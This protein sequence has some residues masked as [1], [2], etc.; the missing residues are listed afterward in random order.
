VMGGGVLG[1][2]GGRW[3][4]WGGAGWP[5]RQV[6]EGGG[7]LGG[8]GVRWVRKGGGGALVVQQGTL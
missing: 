4:Q 3:V 5:G 2:L 8:L 1:G 6:G 7:V